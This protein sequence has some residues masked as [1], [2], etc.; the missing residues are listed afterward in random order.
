MLQKRRQQPEKCIW[1]FMDQC[2]V[3]CP[4]C[5][6]KA[7]VEDRGEEMEPRLIL[8]C[9]SCALKKSK[10]FRSSVVYT[11][12]IVIK[13]H[14]DA[15]LMGAPVDP[16]FRLPLWLQAD[17][18]GHTLWFYNAEHMEFVEDYVAAKLRERKPHEHYRN[19]TM[20][21]RLPTWIKLAKNRDAVL[22]S[23]VELKKQ[24]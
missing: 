22:K 1:D 20:S 14:E 16:H 13:D 8:V 21:S 3:R 23:I 10:R 15:M 2:V 4:R 24:I 5:D 11:G 12:G 18:K 6:S 19:K 7:L 9:A 17:C